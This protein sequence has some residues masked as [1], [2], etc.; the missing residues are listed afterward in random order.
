MDTNSKQEFIQGRWFKI[1][2]KIKKRITA[3][4]DKIKDWVM[5]PKGYF[6]I[7]IDREKNIILDAQSNEKRL[8]EE[9]NTLIDTEKKLNNANSEIITEEKNLINDKD[10]ILKQ[11]SDDDVN[12]YDELRHILYL[13]PLIL[14]VTFSIIYFFSKKLLLFLSIASIFIFTIQNF[15][16]YPYQY[17]WF[18][19]FSN[20]I[21]INIS[22]V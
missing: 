14:I 22:S 9:K 11:L 20:F 3:S 6:L 4:Y 17:T 12:L 5:D 8:N 13:I 10:N 16:M 21:N 2:K 7:D 15:N 18:N 1:N 19:L